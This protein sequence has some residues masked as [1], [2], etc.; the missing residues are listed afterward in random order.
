[1]NKR[2][3]YTISGVIIAILIVVVVYTKFFAPN[4]SYLARYDDV[5]VSANYTSSLYN[6]ANNETLANKIGAPIGPNSGYK[7]I[8]NGTPL[9]SNGR[10][11]VMYFGAEFCPYCAV[12][13]WSLIIAMMRFGNFSKLRY[14]TSAAADILN[15][16]PT[17]TFYNSTYT[18]N[19][20]SFISVEFATNLLNPNTSSYYQLQVPNNLE[21][22]TVSR[23]GSGG[24]PFIDFG[25]RS[26]QNGA[27]VNPALIR[28]SNWTTVLSNMENPDSPVSQNLIGGANFFTAQICEMTNNTPSDVCSQP[29]VKDIERYS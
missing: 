4:Y 23:Y 25:N 28:G 2:S 24:I 29:Y 17:F 15:Y 20:I 12:T 9:I 7:L 18:S 22:K 3:I 16:T 21:N 11:A 14:M 8:S 19:Y 5:N 27:L 6:V 26:V 10:P 1:M 13:R